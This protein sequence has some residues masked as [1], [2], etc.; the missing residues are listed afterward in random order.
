MQSVAWGVIVSVAVYAGFKV[1]YS[2]SGALKISC[3]KDVRHLHA[4]VQ[5]SQFL[6]HFLAINLSLWRQGMPY[7]M[8][9]LSVSLNDIKNV[10]LKSNVAIHKAKEQ[11]QHA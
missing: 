1:T 11:H 5:V 7:A 3:W 2:Q 9:A 8:P 6:Y 4:A 10:I